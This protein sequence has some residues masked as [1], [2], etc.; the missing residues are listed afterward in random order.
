[1]EGFYDRVI[2]LVDKA[3]FKNLQEFILSLGMNYDTYYTRKSRG[4]LPRADE[5]LAIAKA[6]GTTVEYL[7]T[8]ERPNVADALRYWESLGEC[9]KRL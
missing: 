4:A 5:A 6:L 9:L 7:I 1:M 2:T 3:G 8:G